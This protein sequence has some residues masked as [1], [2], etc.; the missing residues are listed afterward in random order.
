MSWFWFVGRTVVGPTSRMNA[1]CRDRRKLKPERTDRIGNRE[2]DHGGICRRGGRSCSSPGPPHP[3]SVTADAWFPTREDPC[4]GLATYWRMCKCCV[5]YSL[6]YLLTKCAVRVW[7]FE[8]RFAPSLN[9]QC[10]GIFEEA[11]Y[12]EKRLTL[13]ERGRNGCFKINDDDDV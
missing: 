4:P 2:L 8:T 6:T 13:A 10:S 11:S 3:T 1:C 9:G 12:R 5:T 7:K